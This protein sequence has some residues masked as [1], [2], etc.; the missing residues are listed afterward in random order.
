MSRASLEA[1]RIC[2]GYGRDEVL[3]NVSIALAGGEVLGVVGPNG[4]GKSTLVRALTGLVPLHSGEVRLCGRS[5]SEL[6]PKE[7][8]RLCAVQPQSESPAFDYAVG[9][10]VMLGRHPHR[11]AL[12][13]ASDEDREA[14]HR[15]MD[16]ADIGGLAERGLRA[17][18]LGE[19]QRVLL[20]RALAQQTPL[21]LLDEPAAHLDPGHRYGVHVLLQRLA[22]ENGCGVLCVSHDLSL[23]SE[24]CD[25]IALMHG[26]GI[27]AVGTPEE[28][29]REELLQDVFGCSALRVAPN[30]FTGRPGTFFTQ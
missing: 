3:H 21:L 23:A 19:W 20:A 29:L 7:R 25:C 2:A 14:V 26:G 1:S 24:F 30:P 17:L 18:S 15:A 8:A 22:R 11:A 13:A 12:G 16:Q 10:F 5:L 27:A 28:V 9:E 4:S 6:S